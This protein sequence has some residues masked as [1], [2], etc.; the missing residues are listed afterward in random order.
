[1]ATALLC[2]ALVFL[3]WDYL[4]LHKELAADHKSLVSIKEDTE[5]MRRIHAEFKK[6][7]SV[8]EHRIAK[9]EK[10][11]SPSKA[12]HVSKVLT[13]LAK[14]E[15]HVQHEDALLRKV[16]RLD[17]D[18]HHR[19]DLLKKLEKE[20]KLTSKQVTHLKIAEKKRSCLADQIGKTQRGGPFRQNY[21]RKCRKSRQEKS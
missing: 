15:T 17:A 8:F 10:Q 5:N 11:P 6:M 16:A 4:Q 20:E 12:D 9:L 13:K 14:L 21:G 2:T 3:G 7:A 18:A 1:M 19:D